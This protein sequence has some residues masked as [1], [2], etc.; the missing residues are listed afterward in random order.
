MAVFACFN[1]K[2]MQYDVEVV[3]L[4]LHDS[5]AR[6]SGLTGLISGYGHISNRLS[7]ETKRVRAMTQRLYF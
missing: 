1:H 3:N 7:V 2:N 4:Q 5:H 6:Y